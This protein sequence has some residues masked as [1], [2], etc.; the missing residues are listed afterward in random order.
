ML[1]SYLEFGVPYG[2]FSYAY[3]FGPTFDRALQTSMN[4]VVDESGEAYLSPLRCLLS[5]SVVQYPYGEKLP[6]NLDCEIE[7]SKI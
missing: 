6:V 3:N 1:E 2:G 4:S 7:I 5:Y